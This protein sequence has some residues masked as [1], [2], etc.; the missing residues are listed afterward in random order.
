MPGGG[1]AIYED[2]NNYASMSSA[3]MKLWQG[4]NQVATFG[5]TITLAP[6]VSADTTDSIKIAAGG[7][8]IYDNQY[9]YVHI[10]PTGFDVYT[11]ISSAAVKVAQFGATMRVG[12]DAADKSA[13]RVAAD[14]SMSIGTSAVSAV[15]LTAIGALTVSGSVTANYGTIGG[16]TLS[17]TAL[18]G[19][20][21]D[22]SKDGT[23]T[24]GDLTGAGTRTNSQIILEGETG[25]MEFRPQMSASNSVSDD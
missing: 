9:E 15:S 11:D 10:G 6:D 16:W 14:G 19:T 18:T 17:P 12:I 20:N 8:K 3:G 21:V 2:S 23:L 24:V 25:H 13:L 5:S 4:G 1:V 7:V 22:L